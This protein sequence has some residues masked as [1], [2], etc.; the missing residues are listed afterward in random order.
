MYS[1]LNIFLII[2]AFPIYNDK[3]TN[4]AVVTGSSSGIRLETSVLLAKNEFYTYIRMRSLV[5][6]KAKA[7]VGIAHNQG[8]PFQVV[9]LD[10]DGKIH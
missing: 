10:V 8:L 3:T 5:G 2:D 9:Q 6:A 1:K 7:I 4:V